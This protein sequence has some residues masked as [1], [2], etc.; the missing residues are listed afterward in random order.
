MPRLQAAAR[1]KVKKL[2]VFNDGTYEFTTSYIGK[3][4]PWRGNFFD[5]QNAPHVWRP[6]EKVGLLVRSS[7]LWA[8]GRLTYQ[9]RQ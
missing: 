3:T 6:P 5:V 4:L 9:H 2:L 8:L 7:Q 1:T